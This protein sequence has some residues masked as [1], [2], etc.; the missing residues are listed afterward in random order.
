MPINNFTDKS[1]SG[2]DEDALTTSTLGERVRNFAR[3][4]TSG[5][6]AD[7]IAADA[8]DVSIV[9]FGE[10]ETAGKG[11]AGIIARGSNASIVNFGSVATLGGIRDPDPDVDGDEAFAEGLVAEGD[12]FRVVNF[13]R[14]HVEGES[15]SCLVG[16]GA[17]GVVVNY[18]VLSTESF[19]SSAIA[20]DGERAQA[21]NA[22]LI[23]V[24]GEDNTALFATGEDAVAVNRGLILID[25]PRL[26]GV[27]GVI[28]NT[29]VI[30]K[31]VIRIEG[32]RSVGLTGFGDGHWIENLGTIDVHG[33]FSGGI[34]ARGIVSFGLDGVD[35]E[36]LNAGRITTD[37]DLGIGI[38]LGVSSAGKSEGF[39]P[40]ENGSIVNRGA[41]ETEGD[42]AAGI[43]MNGD[44][45]HLVN[46]GR[47][48]ADGG[49]FDSDLLG[50]FRAA[51]VVVTGD[52]AL[53]ENL[54]HGVIISNNAESAAVELNVIEQDGAMTE[55][56]SAL[57]E[58][59]GLIKGA[60]IAVLGGAGEETVINHG[61]IVGDVDLGDGDDTYACGKGSALVGDLVLG[62]GDD[63][64]LVADGSGTLRIAD[65]EAGAGG[66]DIIDV[67]AFF[68]DFGDVLSHA[69][70]KGG[71]TVIA[72][73]GN[74][75]L[76]LEN[77]LL[78]VLD[79]G[80]FQL[81]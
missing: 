74:D 58:N 21:V 16:V 39:S 11:A 31:G 65:F 68:S 55:D 32:E 38:G 57:L 59:R 56:M 66:G 62:G 13:G 35:L 20:V 29:D 19:Q 75:R 64:V 41:I 8:D 40:A 63:L 43:V 22:G 45:H 25:G 54:R 37:G 61:R 78:S 76:V 7:G 79:A 53:V 34:Q 42:G 3:L 60:G 30:N 49:A 70:Q 1:T 69:S 6:L 47:I 77:T 9:N 27:E 24:G 2:F 71:N 52:E 48:V 12:G 23:R 10:V 46:S 15:S 81:A 72:L 17:D 4:A 44:G 14:V 36:I 28:V 26:T 5:E 18:G 50:L 33:F 80:D 73:D 51:G 67:S